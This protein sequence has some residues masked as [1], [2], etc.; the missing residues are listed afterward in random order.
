VR[1][2]VGVRAKEGR[3]QDGGG[4]VPAGALRMR[5]LGLRRGQGS[6]S[7]LGRVGDVAESGR[8]RDVA[9]AGWR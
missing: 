8:R 6:G 5:Q 7:Q 2:R 9:A 1:R 3:R 4:W